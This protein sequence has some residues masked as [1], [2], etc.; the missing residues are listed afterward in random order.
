MCLV[1]HG[2]KDLLVTT[3]SYGG[4]HAYIVGTDHLE[5][6]VSNTVGGHQ[7]GSMNAVGITTDGRGQL[8]VCDTN[9]SCI[10]MFSTDGTFLGTV[11]KSGEERFGIPR[12]IGWCNKRKSAV[13]AHDK[14]G[15]CSI[16][17]FQC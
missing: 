5:W 1:T 12:K 10:Q 11:L 3:H 14:H 17:A 13:I 7:P 6:R 8:F 9:N 2:K 16:G 4:I 15:L